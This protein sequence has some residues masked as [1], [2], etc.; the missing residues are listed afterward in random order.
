MCIAAEGEPWKSRLRMLG[1]CDM[2]GMPEASR[3]GCA[4]VRLVTC[5]SRD[6][7]SCSKF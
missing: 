6:G 2:S 1:L 5:G 7:S 4:R 3:L